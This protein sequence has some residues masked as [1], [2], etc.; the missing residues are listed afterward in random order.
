MKSISSIGVRDTKRESGFKGNF[1]LDI[2]SQQQ[3]AA[4]WTRI[5]SW[6][7]VMGGFAI[8]NPEGDVCILDPMTFLKLLKNDTLTIPRIS[9]TEI[10]EKSNGSGFIKAIAAVQIIYLAAELLGRAIQRLAV[11]TLELFTLAMVM[12]ALFLYALWWNK[13]LDVRLPMVLEVKTGD[14][15]ARATLDSTYVISRKRVG[16]GDPGRRIT[17]SEKG[18]WIAVTAV[19]IF[20]A[21][22]LIGWNFDFPT[23]V[24]SLLWR[25]ASVCCVVLPLG[26]LLVDAM[27]SAG[28]RYFAWF[29]LPLGLLYVIVR[30]YLIVEVFVGL[31]RVPASVYQ[32]VQWSQ[33][34]PHF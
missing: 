16:F 31:R 17:T 20:G 7:A 28:D 9:V 15:G 19:I 2:H 1:I 18:I 32:T 6:F 25:I 11:T 12:M 30:L 23:Y 34:F 22:H 5:H 14:D 10:E 13:P 26:I 8:Q 21:C 33:F 27:V 4:S 24:E 3:K 29:V